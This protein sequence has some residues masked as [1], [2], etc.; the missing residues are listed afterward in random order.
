MILRLE[1]FK[2]RALIGGGAVI[3]RLIKLEYR[4]TLSI[5][6]YDSSTFRRLYT[7]IGNWW[8]SMRDL[9]RIS[10]SVSCLKSMNTY[11]WGCFVALLYTWDKKVGFSGY[12]CLP[13]TAIWVAS[14]GFLNKTMYCEF[15]LLV[16]VSLVLKKKFCV[17]LITKSF[18]WCTSLV[19]KL[20]TPGW[21]LASCI[22][23][24]STITL[25]GGMSTKVSGRPSFNI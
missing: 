19:N 6:V 16:R 11:P 22:R 13:M 10:S 1:V 20:V 12:I 8:G 17:M 4:F 18:L 14:E 9:M 23:S 24:S 3:I 21:S 2:S 5:F 25:L 7:C 15:S